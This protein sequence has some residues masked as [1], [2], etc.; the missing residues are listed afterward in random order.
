M[1]IGT[2]LG[3]RRALH[4]RARHRARLRDAGARAHRPERRPL[5]RARSRHLRRDFLPLDRRLVR[6][7]D[8]RCDLLQRARRQP[9]R[10]TSATAR[11]PAGLPSASITPAILDKLPDGRPPRDRRRLRRVDPDRLHHRRPDRLH[12]LPRSWFIPHV[13][14]RRG[15]GA[16]SADFGAQARH[17]AAAS[18]P[19][20][21]RDTERRGRGD[22]SD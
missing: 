9:G 7:R 14:L 13:E 12:R 10:A 22:G 3:R 21:S 16:A 8:L 11:L 4:V 19:S 20:P 6:H 5:L 15:V 18:P 1:G 2:S 17:R